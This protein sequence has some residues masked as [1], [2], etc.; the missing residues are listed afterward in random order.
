M[1]DANWSSSRSFELLFDRVQSHT[2][3]TNICLP[4][5]FTLATLG[6]KA[7]FIQAT[8]SSACSCDSRSDSTAEKS[9]GCS[10]DRRLCPAE[11]Q[12]EG[13]AHLAWSPQTSPPCSDPP[14]CP[15]RPRSASS[16][17]T[18]WGGAGWARQTARSRTGPERTKRV[19]CHIQTPTTFK[20]NL[21]LKNQ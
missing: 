15:S 17:R 16:C 6:P 10:S 20:K 14:R 21:K 8:R 12:T 18:P 1:S 11:S 5:T 3:C 4:V 19:T 13:G 9:S 2:P 7:F